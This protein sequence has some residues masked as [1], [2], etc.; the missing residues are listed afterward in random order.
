MG[1]L[2][3]ICFFSL[4]SSRQTMLRAAVGSAATSLSSALL[5][6]LPAAASLPLVGRRMMSKLHLTRVDKVYDSVAE[7]VDGVEDG[8]SIMFGGFGLCGIPEGLIL[9]L[10]QRGS[11]DLTC[12]SN[13]AGVSDFG[14][15][16][17]LASGQVS[18]MVASYV[19]ENSEFEQ[20][21]MDGR[22]EVQFVPQGTLA[23]RIRSAAAGIPAFYTPTGTGTLVEEGGM[24]MRMAA[25]GSVA[26]ASEAEEVREF[27]G[28]RYVMQ[29]ALH[30]DWALVKAWKADALGN[31]VFRGT[32]NN[33]NSSMAKAGKICV[34]EVENI[35]PIG[36]LS[37]DEI[38]VPGIYVDRIVQCHA[39]KRIERIRLAG[40]ETRMSKRR[41][42]IARRAAKEMKHGMYVNLGIGMPVLA[43]TFLPEGCIIEVQSENGVLGMG[44]YPARVEDVDE[45]LINASKETIALLPG[46]SVFSSEES[47]NMIR[48]GHLDLTMLG[49]MQVSAAGDLANW[50]IPGQK[51]K[52]MGG[53]MDLVSSGSRVVVTMSHLSK[54]GS[55]KIVST[56]SLPVTGRSVVDR[57]ITEY[58]VFDVKLDGAGLLLKEKA[59]DKSV[60]ELRA[61]TDAPF[62]VDEQLQTF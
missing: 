39:P 22:L 51:V 45:D 6:T 25:D 54:D 49:A 5:P 8:S 61:M 62:D 15:G 31:L 40:Q 11:A 41:E 47:F 34:A 56:C 44:G 14:L 28:K 10:L 13:T 59:E 30:A 53:A 36:E 50:I 19:G 27:D 17:L 37:P 29:R 20:R 7:A 12:I 1:K 35:V 55:P 60:E 26:V 42:R 9:A 32:S 33:F 23:E 43:S 2:S 38:D 58:A 24:P 18:K 52:G 48:G 16:Q 57:I 4:L 46:A 3:F 21:F